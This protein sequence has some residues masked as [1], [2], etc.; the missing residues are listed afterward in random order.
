[1]SNDPKILIPGAGL[2]S[3]F[4][5]RPTDIHPLVMARALSRE[6][7]YANLGAHDYYVA[8]HL[9]IVSM[10]CPDAALQALV[11]DG[12]EAFLG[13]MIGPLKK[14]LRIVE[15]KEK[16]TYDVIEEKWW[17]AVADRFWVPRR[18]ADRVEYVDK[19]LRV[20][21]QRK[22][23]PG[24]EQVIHKNDEVS[25]RWLEEQSAIAG[26]R[27]PVQLRCLSSGEAYE[28]YVDRLR[29]LAPW[30]LPL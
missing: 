30:S 16:S 8:E 13:D 29:E 2:V 17:H 25:V 11:H 18:I 5:P 9:W 24:S 10:L 26:L 12:Q 3:L 28:L 6:G 7:R 15:G 22:L 20:V 23:F 19:T 4:E 27:E 1:M 14:L 21:E